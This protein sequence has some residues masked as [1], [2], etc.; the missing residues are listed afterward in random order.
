MKKRKDFHDTAEEALIRLKELKESKDIEE[1]EDSE[2]CP[3]EAISSPSEE[4][5]SPM[6]LGFQSIFDAKSRTPEI[7]SSSEDEIER[8]QRTSKKTRTAPQQEEQE[9]FDNK[10]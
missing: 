7:W 6:V 10:V 9:D 8:E 2:Y 4:E 5:N 1:M 3:E